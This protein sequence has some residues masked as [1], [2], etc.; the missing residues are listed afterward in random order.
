MLDRAWQ[1]LT[2]T[3]DPI[4]TSLQRSADDAVAAGVTETKWICVGSTTCRS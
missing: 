3:V 2:V 4:A 1:N